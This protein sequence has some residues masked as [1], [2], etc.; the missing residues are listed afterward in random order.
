MQVLNE[1]GGE[2]YA[3]LVQLAGGDAGIVM[4][5][6]AKSNDGSVPL[7]KVVS[8]IKHLKQQQTTAAPQHPQDAHFMGANKPRTIEH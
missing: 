1:K 6:M 5:A 3:M 8:D 4:Q 7:S 2:I